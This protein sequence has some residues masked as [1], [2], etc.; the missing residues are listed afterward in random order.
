SVPSSTPG[1]TLSLHDALPIYSL[2]K[3][4]LLPL[5]SL[6]MAFGFSFAQTSRDKGA[7]Q[8]LPNIVLIYLDDMGYGD[9]PLTGATGYRTPN[10]RSEEH[11][12]ELQS[13][14]NLVCRLL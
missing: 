3:S 14:E 7:A 9:L 4:I 1:S 12:S 10:I 8:S 13:R 2:L 11:T 5:F 6:L